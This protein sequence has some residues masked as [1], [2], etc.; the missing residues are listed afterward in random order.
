[1]ARA[2]GWRIMAASAAL[3]IGFGAGAP[4]AGPGVA[5]AHEFDAGDLHIDHPYARVIIP[6]RPAAAYF[7]IENKGA[8]DRLLGASTPAFGRVELHTHEASNG[9]VRMRKVPHIN[10]TSDEGAQLQPGGDH[11]MLF[12]MVEP[13]QVGDKFPMTLRFERAGEVDVVVH[14][15]PI[16]G[17]DHSAHAGHAHGAPDEM[18]GESMGA[19]TGADQLIQT[20]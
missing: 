13:L 11:V 16:S 5:V 15:E 7:T 8:D 9:V 1:M 19:D 6:S 20:P 17:P 18:H 12:D 14:V 4:L 2:F 10:V 3:A